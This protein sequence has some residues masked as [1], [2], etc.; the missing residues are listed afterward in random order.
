M[1]TVLH[2]ADVHLGAKYVGLGTKGVLQRKRLTE[3]FKKV[4][5]VA[6]EKGVNLVLVAGDLFDSTIPSKTNIDVVNIVIKELAETGVCVAIS[7]GTH[8]YLAAGS[9]FV[10]G[11]IDDSHENV[12]VFK[13]PKPTTYL[14]EK[15]DVAV[16]ARSLD[17]NKSHNS[18]FEGLAPNENAAVNLAM[19]HG[20]VD[21]PG[22]KIPKDDWIIKQEDLKRSQFDYVAL[23]HW[24]SAR[25]IVKDKAWYSGSPEWLSS[26]Q[27]ESGQ[28][29]IVS[30]DNKKVKAEPVS[31]GTTKFDEVEIDVGSVKNSEELKK[32]I[33]ERADKTVIRRVTLKGIRP[34]DIALNPKELEEELGEEF[35][36]LKIF[37]NSVVKMD[38]VAEDDKTLVSE[39]VKVMGNKSSKADDEKK[40]EIEDATWI[41]IKLLK[42]EEAGL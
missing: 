38:A 3:T 27:K 22:L 4:P 30:I 29:L 32:K 15:L 39:F 1:V 16:S 10:S 23:G 7:A 20:S 40:K 37:D 5:E 36:V 21:I 25:E 6:K 34:K 9:V 35:W 2:L 24:H 28:M 19:A 42:G 12:F 26:D 33:L 18:P 41:G 11:A 14:F 8:D 31:I 13:E 17:S